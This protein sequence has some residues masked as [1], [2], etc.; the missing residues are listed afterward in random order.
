MIDGRRRH[1]ITEA[2][3]RVIDPQPFDRA[4]VGVEFDHDA[5]RMRF[6]RKRAQLVLK[7]I[8][9]GGVELVNKP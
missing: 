8:E 3:A 7:S 1:V 4:A 5:R 6:A 9:A 2:I